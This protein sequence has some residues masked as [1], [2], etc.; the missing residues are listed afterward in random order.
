M[1]S[2]WSGGN[3]RVPGLDH[4]LFPTPHHSF[5]VSLKEINSIVGGYPIIFHH[6]K[7]LSRLAEVKNVYLMGYYDEKKFF[8]FIDYVKTLFN[9]KVSYVQE[10]IPFNTTGALFYYKDLLLKDKP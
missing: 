6:L 9:Y 5:Q 7:A 3:P 1:Q 8:P 10:E 4:S 2:F